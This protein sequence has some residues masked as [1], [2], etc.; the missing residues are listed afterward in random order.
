MQGLQPTPTR[1]RMRS[2]IWTWRPSLDRRSSGAKR[3]ASAGA[4]GRCAHGRPDQAIALQ[5]AYQWLA[6]AESNRREHLK[7]DVARFAVS[8]KLSPAG[9]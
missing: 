5:F 7:N 8:R 4:A 9:R 1:R 6:V 2:P 3:P